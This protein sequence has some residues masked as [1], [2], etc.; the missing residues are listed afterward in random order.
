MEKRPDLTQSDSP[1]ISNMKSLTIIV[2]ANIMRVLD[3][4]TIQLLFHPLHNCA[5]TSL[6]QSEFKEFMKACL[7]EEAW[8][9]VIVYDFEKNTKHS[10]MEF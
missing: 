8:G 10:V 1:V 5:S 9:K 2:D 4:I 3:G 6:T 7:G